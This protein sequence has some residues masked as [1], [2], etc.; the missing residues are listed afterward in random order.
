V[1]R[2]DRWMEGREFAPFLFAYKLFR[3]CC[4]IQPCMLQ[5]TSLHASGLSLD[6][7]TKALLLLLLLLLL[8]TIEMDQRNG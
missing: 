7:Y 2:K 1:E 3:V 5:H 4:S 6:G 8:F